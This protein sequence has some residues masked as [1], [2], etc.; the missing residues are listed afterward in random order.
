MP[1]ENRKRGKKFKKT[2]E[3]PQEDYPAEP[4]Y[5]EPVT[6]AGPS[7]IKSADSQPQVLDAPFG[8]IE[9]DVK[10][11]FRTVDVQIKQWI[12]EA[13]EPV[14]GEEE[15]D[16][17]EGAFFS[18]TAFKAKSHMGEQIEGCSSWLPCRK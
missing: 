7:W 1:R 17:N 2:Q 6:D 9:Q 3:E 18:S 8:D 14:E 11:Y 13:P 15:K 12:E 4:T 16:P 5:E 10:A